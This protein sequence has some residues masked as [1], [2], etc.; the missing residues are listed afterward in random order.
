MTLL[1]YGLRVFQK[2]LFDNS[3]REEL[4]I[5]EKEREISKASVKSFTV[6]GLAEQYELTSSFAEV[7]GMSLNH[8]SKTNKVLIIFSCTVNAGSVSGIGYTEVNL[9]LQKDGVDIEGTENNIY[10]APQGDERNFIPCTIH[11]VADNAER[12]T[13][14]IVGKKIDFVGPNDSFINDRIITVIDL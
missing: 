12:N 7:T 11:W 3:R 14:R 6:G 4:G 10:I 5:I 8:E 9:K 1:G 2:N 13:W